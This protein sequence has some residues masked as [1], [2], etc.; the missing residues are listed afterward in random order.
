MMSP[1]YPINDWCDVNIYF[2]IGKAIFN[3]HTLYTEAFDH[4]GPLIFFIYGI[5]YLI[6]NTSF[7]GVFIIEVI[8]WIIMLNAVFFTAKLFINKDFAAIT[9]LLFSVLLLFYTEQGG[10]AE[11]FAVICMSPSLYFFIKYFLTAEKSYTHRPGSMFIH[12]AMSAMVFLIKLNLAIFWVVPLFYIFINILLHKKYANL[13]KNLISYTAGFLLIALPIIIYFIYNHSLTNAYDIYIILNRNYA[14][15]PE[16]V[17]KVVTVILRKIIY[18]FYDSPVGFLFMFAGIFVFPYYFFK[19][20]TK[21]IIFILWGMSVFFFVHINRRHYPY[22]DIPFAIFM[23]PGLI[24]LLHYIQ[25]TIPI[26]KAASVLKIFFLICV[27]C[28]I[29]ITQFFDIYPRDFFNERVKVDVVHDFGNVIKEQENPI[30]LNLGFGYGNAIFTYCNIVPSFTYS[31]TPNIRHEFYPDIRNEQTRY[32]ENK[33]PDFIILTNV[34]L[35]YDYFNNLP[36]LNESYIKTDSVVV[37]KHYFK[38]IDKFYTYYL[39]RRG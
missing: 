32:I 28:G 17:L 18:I 33:E 22:Y 21:R 11:E 38:E 19:G 23:V 27:L 39:Y 36:A 4:K 14:Q 37:R 25:H 5:G 35:N 9:A 13:I 29:S 20:R 10:S 3:G 26:K 12:G 7:L 30:I 1:L 2:N 31:M 15:M 34:S 24:S 6:S 16:S 8:G